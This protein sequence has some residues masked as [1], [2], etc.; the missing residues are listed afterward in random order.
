MKTFY[1]EF[2]HSEF[3]GQQVCQE[4]IEKESMAEAKKYA[5]SQSYVGLILKLQER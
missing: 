2:I 3:P 1:L 4:F 5:E